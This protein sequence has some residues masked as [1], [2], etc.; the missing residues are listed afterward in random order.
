MH[1]ESDIA[2]SSRLMRSVLK[3]RGRGVLSW[4]KV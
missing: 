3:L 2:W 1:P 4:D